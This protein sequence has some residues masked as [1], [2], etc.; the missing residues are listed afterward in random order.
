M[1]GKYFRILL[2]IYFDPG[3]FQTTT[4]Y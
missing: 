3:I 1:P 2:N 4:A